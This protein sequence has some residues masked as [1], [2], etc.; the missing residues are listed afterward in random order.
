MENCTKLFSMIRAELEICCQRASLSSCR[1]KDSGCF[2]DIILTMS[3]KWDSFMQDS[4]SSMLKFV[5][6]H[7]KILPIHGE[8]RARTN[9]VLM[10]FYVC[11]ELNYIL[12]L[13]NK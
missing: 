9:V 11:Y 12:C 3:A 6:R 8:V 1:K 10:N 5:P 7:F 4:V 13:T 2:P